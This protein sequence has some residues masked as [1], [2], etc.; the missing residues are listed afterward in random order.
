MSQPP[1]LRDVTV[2]DLS[3]VGPGTRCAR[4]L[5]DYGARIIKIGVPPRH[6]GLQIEPAWWA[7]GAGRGWLR[8]RID[9]KAP[10]GREAF[11]ALAGRADVVIESF[12]P[13]VATRLGVDFDAVAA[14]NPRIVYCSTT[15]YGQDGPRA[16][17]A[18]HDLDYLAVGGYLSCSDAGPTAGRRCPERR[19]PTRQPAACTPHSRSSPRCCGALRRATANTWTCRSPTACCR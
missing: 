1:A 15:G 6:A 8:A 14:R 4:I 19:S 12:R 17:W 18:G 9:L 3:T 11:F 7:Y 10:S 5:A 13:G 2:L 16:Q